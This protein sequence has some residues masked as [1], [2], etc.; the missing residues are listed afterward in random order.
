M[1]FSFNPSDAILLH[2]FLKHINMSYWNLAGMHFIPLPS[3]CPNFP[4]THNT[5]SHI[6]THLDTRQA[7]A[8]LQEPRYPGSSPMQPLGT[9]CNKW[10]S[11]VF[12]QYMGK[13]LSYPLKVF[14]PHYI[15]RSLRAG[16]LLFFVSPV[17]CLLKKKKSLL[18]RLLY[19][20]YVLDNE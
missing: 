19:Y 4:T 5:L 9:G 10:V 3:I 14:L 2:A 17:L 12:L 8:Y 16:T 7:F 1:T 11:S 18:T 15:V 6:D 13:C 20:R